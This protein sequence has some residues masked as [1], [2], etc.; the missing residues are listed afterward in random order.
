MLLQNIYYS[1]QCSDKKKKKRE[2]LANHEILIKNIRSNLQIN[3]N[4]CK[5]KFIR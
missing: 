3:Q 2:I 1:L 4:K 5:K